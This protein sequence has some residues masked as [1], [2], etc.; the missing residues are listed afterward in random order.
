MGSLGFE[1]TKNIKINIINNYY[2]KN[3]YIKKG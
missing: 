2:L 3:E 1:C